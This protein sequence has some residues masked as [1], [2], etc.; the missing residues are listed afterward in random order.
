MCS[1]VSA[2]ILPSRHKDAL[3]V[4]CTSHWLF[5]QATEKTVLRGGFGISYTPFPDN[6]YAYNY[7]VRANNS[8]QP[9]NTYGPALLSDGSVSTFQKGFPTPVAVVIPTN[10]LIAISAA[11]TPQL[12]SQQYN[13]IPKN[14]FNPYVESWNVAVQQ[15]LPG[16]LSFQLA[17]VANHGVHMPVNQN[18]NL[19]SV[20]GGGVASEPENILF[21]H[22]AA[23]NLVFAGF[24]SNYESLQAQLTR[25][26]PKAC[27]SPPPSPGAR[28][29]IT[30]TM[31]TGVSSSSPSYVATTLRRTTIG[32]STMSRALPTSYLP[33]EATATSAPVRP[34]SCLAV[35]GPLG[36][37]PLSRA[38]PSPSTRT[39][40][41]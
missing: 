9:G 41:R 38:I 14:Y 6:N 30:P 1:R 17:Y 18:I 5:L 33:V 22:T 31:T 2:A 34:S 23:T 28:P 13:V 11:A 16:D 10:G 40:D 32:A 4:L 36:S 12:N 35:G 26:S 39:A 15:A 29:S 19:P 25:V 7:S 24:S 3:F 20:L 37:S 27:H 21:K 8:F